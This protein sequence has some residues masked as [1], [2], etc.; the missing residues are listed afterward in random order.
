MLAHKLSEGGIIM[1]DEYVDEVNKFPGAK[2]AID[3]FL[4]SGQFHLEQHSFSG[5]YF[6]IHAPK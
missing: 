6:L 4:E 2:R 5:K 3:E 1:V